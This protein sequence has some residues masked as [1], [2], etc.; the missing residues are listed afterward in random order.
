MTRR[1]V[2]VRGE[3]RVV[4][5]HEGAAGD[6]RLTQRQSSEMHRLRHGRVHRVRRFRRHGSRWHEVKPKRGRGGVG[7]RLGAGYQVYYSVRVELSNVALMN[8]DLSCSFR[9]RVRIADTSGIYRAP[10]VTPQAT[11]T[12]ALQSIRRKQQPRRN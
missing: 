4:V 1:S 10:R 11:A 7:R 8:L 6:Q 2:R 12:R 9:Q 3:L 5:D